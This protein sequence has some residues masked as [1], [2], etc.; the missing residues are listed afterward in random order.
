M[1]SANEQHTPASLRGLLRRGEPFKG[2]EGAFERDF[3][4]K[5]QREVEKEIDRALLGQ[6]GP[7]DDGHV[8]VEDGKEHRAEVVIDVEATSRIL[9]D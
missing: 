2:I 6:A 7:A 9:D 5:L 1:G 4:R 3:R 8:L